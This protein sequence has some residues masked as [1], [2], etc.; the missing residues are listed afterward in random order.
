MRNQK[1]EYPLSLP[2]CGHSEL[3]L[4]T[5]MHRSYHTHARPCHPSHHNR[6]SGSIGPI[7]LSMFTPILR[8]AWL[9][10]SAWVIPLPLSHC[11][12]CSFKALDSSTSFIFVC[13]L[14]YCWCSRH[15]NYSCYQSWAGRIWKPSMAQSREGSSLILD[16]GWRQ[17]KLCRRRSFLYVLTNLQSARHETHLGSRSP[18]KMVYLHWETASLQEFTAFVCL[19]EGW[20]FSWRLQVWSIEIRF[21]LRW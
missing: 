17:W 10:V 16:N 1:W 7:H 9:S 14:Y 3:W 5:M 2:G 21:S 11:L 15:E 18:H 20:V 19:L 4:L 8:L 6:V 13:L 12:L